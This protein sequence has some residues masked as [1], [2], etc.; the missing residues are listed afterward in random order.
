MSLGED[1]SRH[2]VRETKI[3]EPEIGLPRIMA[4]QRRV[5][6]MTEF[7]FKMKTGGEFT[8]PATGGLT[9]RFW[10]RVKVEGCIAS[11]IGVSGGHFQAGYW[12]VETYDRHFEYV[13]LNRIDE[14]E[15][16]TNESW[17]GG[18]EPALFL[19]TSDFT[20]AMQYASE[21]FEPTWRTI[22]ELSVGMN[23][24]EF[25]QHDV[26]TGKPGWW[27]V[28]S[29][30]D[31]LYNQHKTPGGEVG[32]NGGGGGEGVNA[33]ADAE[34]EEEENV[35]PEQERVQVRPRTRQS[36]AIHSGN[37]DEERR[38]DHRK[39]GRHDSPQRGTKRSR[40]STL[41]VAHANATATT[42]TGQS[43]P[44]PASTSSQP[45][46]GPSHVPQLAP[47]APIVD[48]ADQSPTNN[49]VRWPFTQRF[50]ESPLAASQSSAHAELSQSDSRGRGD[51]SGSVDGSSARAPT[52]DDSRMSVSSVDLSRDEPTAFTSSDAAMHDA[53]P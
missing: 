47:S 6:T 5:R 36:S 50:P 37:N 13:E 33:D 34:G 27:P 3:L 14:M 46:P 19:K 23:S 45:R 42:S 8:L 35:E 44:L 1:G 12:D 11:V 18:T 24:P 22:V 21:G 2:K 26:M 9:P 25:R 38:K 53:L 7:T 32:G 16:G 48:D 29:D 41:V 40:R 20:Y 30:W 49:A 43:Q 52:T 17:R 28:E 51:D 31:A 39:R 10:R 15:F 4:G